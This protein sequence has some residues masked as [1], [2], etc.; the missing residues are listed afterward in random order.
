MPLPEADQRDTLVLVVAD[1]AVRHHPDHPLGD[2]LQRF[3]S[4]AVVG[5]SSIGQ[6]DNARVRDNSIVVTV[7]RFD[8]TTL[9]TA[10]VDIASAGGARRAGRE[11]GTA[12][13]DSKLRGVLVLSDGLNVDGAALAAGIAE[14]LPGV[15]ISGGLAGDGQQSGETWVLAD[16][17]ARCGWV[18]AVGFVGDHISFGFGSAGGWDIF[19]P[20]RVVTRSHAS[21]L[22]ELDN[23]PA[24]SMYRTY[25][26]DRVNDMATTAQHFPLLVRDI[27]GIATVRSVVSI[28]ERT[29]SIRFAGEIPQ[30]SMAQLM[31]A[32]TDRLIN[33]AHD[34]AQQAATGSEQLALAVSSAGRRL[35]LGERAGEEL[36]A[37]IEAFAVGTP[38]AGFYSSGELSPNNG[39][40]SLHNQTMTFTTISERAA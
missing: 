9:V 2:V 27:D 37:A 31:R 16:G 10:A 23:R 18:T 11:L 30:G 33:G 19:G 8:R 40:C 29:Q 14:R 35:V 20:Q 3:D 21:V 34:A 6:V 22:Y 4:K 38:L 25:L 15:P 36:E 5:C 12:M 24:L 1:P 13:V 28:D 32:R 7:A 17:A 26:G 39:L